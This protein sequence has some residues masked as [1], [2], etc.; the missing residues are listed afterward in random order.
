MDI[1]N[2]QPQ[3]S[4]LELRCINYRVMLRVISPYIDSHLTAKTPSIDKLHSL[5]FRLLESIDV[6]EKER[7]TLRTLLTDQQFSSEID[8]KVNFLIKEICK[9]Y[10]ALTA[11]YK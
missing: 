5:I 3:I 4:Q 8:Y 1:L 7:L 6:D 9:E 2:D 11:F 10:P